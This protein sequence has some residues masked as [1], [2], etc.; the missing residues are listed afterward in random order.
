[1]SAYRDPLPKEAIPPEPC[2]CKTRKPIEWARV[3]GAMLCGGAFS[4]AADLASMAVLYIGSGRS[5]GDAV[6]WIAVL[7]FI[8]MAAG[9]TIAA[10]AKGEA[11][12]HL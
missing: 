1:M 6:R 4:L 8:T 10:T 5:P 9:L 11:F 2:P 12:P 7:C 3:G